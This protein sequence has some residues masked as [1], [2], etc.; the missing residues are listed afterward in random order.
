MTFLFGIFCGI[1][2]SY[3]FQ[4]ISMNIKLDD[5]KSVHDVMEIVHKNP[6]DKINNWLETFK[7]FYEQVLLTIE[8]KI[9]KSC[10]KVNNYYHVSFMIEHKIYKLILKPI[11]GPDTIIRIENTNK[12]DITNHLIPYINGMKSFQYVTPKILDQKN[13]SIYL[14]NEYVDNPPTI[15]F[16]RDDIISGLF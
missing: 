9:R 12:E 11:R 15:N 10:V 6:S 14:N 1:M 3:S 5:I 4:I 7:F 16:S 13:I 8:Q 2:I